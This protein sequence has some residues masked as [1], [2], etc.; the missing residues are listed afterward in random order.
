MAKD[1]EELIVEKVDVGIGDMDRSAEDGVVSVRVV[2]QRVSA[3]E[4]KTANPRELLLV[5]GAA[6]VAAVAD[7][8]REA[9]QRALADQI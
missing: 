1:V 6:E 5:Y 2:T 7:A 3:V 4:T 8:L 9:S